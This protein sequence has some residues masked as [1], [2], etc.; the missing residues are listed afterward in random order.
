M[1]QHESGSEIFLRVSTGETS[2]GIGPDID[3]D[4]AWIDS[5]SSGNS[6][7]AHPRNALNNDPD[8]KQTS[9]EYCDGVGWKNG[10]IRLS[11]ETHTYDH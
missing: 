7:P 8:Y 5:G 2:W 1:L 4:E 11:C 6:C 3:G 9:W 10:D